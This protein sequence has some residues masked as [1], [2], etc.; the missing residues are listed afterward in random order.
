MIDPIKANYYISGGFAWVE[1][2]E[3]NEI[4]VKLKY[5][6]KGGWGERGLK[7]EIGTFFSSIIVSISQSQWQLFCKR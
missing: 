3:F 4:K 5:F 6:A 2:R 7:G 1:K